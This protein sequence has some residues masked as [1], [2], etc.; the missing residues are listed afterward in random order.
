[1]GG[2]RFAWIRPPASN[3]QQDRQRHVS[4]VRLLLRHHNGRLRQFNIRHQHTRPDALRPQSTDRHNRA[5][6]LASRLHDAHLLP[7]RRHGRLVTSDIRPNPVEPPHDRPHVGQS[8][9]EILR[10]SPL[11][12][13]HDRDQR[14]RQLG[15][16]C[17]RHHGALPHVREPETGPIPLRDPRLRHLP[18]ENRSERPKLPGLPKRLLRALPWPCRW[19]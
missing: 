8:S 7:R 12:L 18:V 13:R 10:R 15:P 2:D 5:S 17:K 19:R 11:R 3:T 14:G 4:G 9:R 16:L 1:M 6:G